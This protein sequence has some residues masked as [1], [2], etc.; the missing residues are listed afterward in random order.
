MNIITKLR[1][2]RENYSLALAVRYNRKKNESEFDHSYH[3][4]QSERGLK[5]KLPNNPLPRNHI[6]NLNDAENIIIKGDIGT[7]KT[8]ML[9]SLTDSLEKY[10]AFLSRGSSAHAPS[11]KD[12]ILFTDWQKMN[13][14]T[15]FL[16]FKDSD[17]IEVIYDSMLKNIP[18]TKEREK[19]LLARIMRNSNENKGS[20]PDTIERLTGI[21][22]KEGFEY[23]EFL[24]KYCFFVEAGLYITRHISPETMFGNYELAFNKQMNPSKVNAK[25]VNFYNLPGEGMSQGQKTMAVLQDIEKKS[26]DLSLTLLDEPTN[27]LPESKI[28]EVADIIQR[29][30]GQKFIATHNE[31]LSR[32]I[33][34]NRATISFYESPVAVKYI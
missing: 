14:S 1:V 22:K 18:F 13:S 33:S 6:L 2:L 34:T 26:T 21:A 30:K 5:F 12:F 10:Q 9:L 23:S 4:N 24:E 25:Y 7:G 32:L 8:T 3:I 19:T 31:T 16:E 28:A 29:T 20:K 27:S 15:L 11:A 17:L